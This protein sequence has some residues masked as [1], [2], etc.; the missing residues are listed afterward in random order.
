MLTKNV[1]LSPWPPQPVQVHHFVT[2][3]EYKFFVTKITC[4]VQYDG[5]PG[6]NWGSQILQDSKLQQQI[7]Y[8]GFIWLLWWFYFFGPCNVSPFDFKCSFHRPKETG[9]FFFLVVV[10]S[11]E[12]QRLS[13]SYKIANPIHQVQQKYSDWYNW[14][15]EKYPSFHCFSEHLPGTSF[16]VL[17]S[18]TVSVLVPKFF[19]NSL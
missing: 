6:D 19:R 5:T 4:K 13:M 18:L 11:A 15:E 8:L 14:R 9:F 10:V 12:N 1:S 17:F 16:S 2:V 3:I 7:L